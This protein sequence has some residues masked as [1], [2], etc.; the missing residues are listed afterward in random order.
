M[1]EGGMRGCYFLLIRNPAELTKF[2]NEA[3][4]TCVYDVGIL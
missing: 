4:C 1:R 3:Q 2:I